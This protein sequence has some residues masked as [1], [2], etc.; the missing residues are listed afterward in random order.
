VA[1]N[2]LGLGPFDRRLTGAALRRGYLAGINEV[3]RRLG[4]DAPY[5][6]WGHSH[7]SGPWPGDDPQEWR[8]PSGGRILNTGSWVYQPHFLGHDPRASPYWPGSAVLLD[9]DEPPR[10]VHLLEEIS[11]PGPA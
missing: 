6:L 1:L 5:V 9:G 7:R 2:A 4:I 8:T 11:L 10:L 3:I